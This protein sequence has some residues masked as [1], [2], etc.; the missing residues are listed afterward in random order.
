MSDYLATATLQTECVVNSAAA[1]QT[2]AQR[3]R[4]FSGEPVTFHAWHLPLGE[5][6][7]LQFYSNSL[8]D[9][10][11]KRIMDVDVGGKISSGFVE[12]YLTEENDFIA[13]RVLLNDGTPA[14]D[15][16]KEN[17]Q[18]LVK[19]GFH[20]ADCLNPKHPGYAELVRYC[21]NAD[22]EQTTS[23]PVT[24]VICIVSEPWL[25]ASLISTPEQPS[26]IVA[27][28]F[29]NRTKIPEKKFYV[30]DFVGKLPRKQEAYIRVAEKYGHRY[31]KFKE[32]D[33]DYVVTS[34]L[35]STHKAVIEANHN[36]NTRVITV[37]EFIELI[38]Y[39]ARRTK[40]PGHD[41]GSKGAEGSASGTERKRRD[42]SYE[43]TEKGGS[44]SSAGQTSSETFVEPEESESP[45]A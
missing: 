45:S 13:L 42:A 28:V 44:N 6:A 31:A 4:V 39:D 34:K 29:K 11:P 27:Y 16:P 38:G 5:Y 7:Q 21:I 30:F 35:D 24:G 22:Q 40:S 19:K 41:N 9:A 15:N 12:G 32:E 26:P 20:T 14:F 43:D 18:F 17:F 2:W 23:Y 37:E 8:V 25:R 3:I 36:K 10:L 1:I 33:V